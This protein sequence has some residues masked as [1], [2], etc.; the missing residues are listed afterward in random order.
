MD[1]EWGIGAYVRDASN[2][3]GLDCFVVTRQGQEDWFDAS[4][5]QIVTVAIRS[6]TR[7]AGDI[8]PGAKI[9]GGGA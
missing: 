5:C 6:T 4:E 9:K 2:R 7:S 8:S 3:D 1:W